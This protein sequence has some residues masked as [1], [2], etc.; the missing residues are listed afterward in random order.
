[1]E[2][3]QLPCLRCVQEVAKEEGGQAG[4]E[5]AVK[6]PAPEDEGA[7]QQA[8]AVPAKKPKQQQAATLSFNLDE[9]N[10]EDLL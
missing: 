3:Y 2:T 8:A 9:E 7:G 5:G 1:M 4:D 10:E 6:R